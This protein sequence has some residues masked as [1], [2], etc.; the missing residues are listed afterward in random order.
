MAEAVRVKHEEEQ[1]AGSTALRMPGPVNRLMDSL[2]RFR[3]FLH[4]VRVEMRNV[5]WPTLSD[6]RGTT[7]V[8]IVTVLFFAVYL[9]IVDRAVSHVVQRVLQSFKP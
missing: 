1:R 6:V 4:E 5:T 9:F 8:V 3:E 2:R 7:V